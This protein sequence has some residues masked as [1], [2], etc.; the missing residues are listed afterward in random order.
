MM[1][2]ARSRDLGFPRRRL[3]GELLAD[4][5]FLHAAD[6]HLDSPLR[7]LSRYEGLPED[8]IRGA[9]RG[10]FDNLV[11]R[12]VD[13]AV[14]FVVIAG[15]LFDG[16]WKDMG[17]G[18]YF[19]RAMGRLHQAGIPVFLLA[20]NHDAASVITRSVPWPPNVRLFGTRKPE[21]HVLAELGVAVHGQSFST[22]AVTDNLVLAYPEATE[23]HFNIGM[24][25]TALAG[26]QGHAPYAPCSLDDLKA[27]QYDYWALGHVHEHEI[28]CEDPHV[29][30]P[31][32]TQGRT[33]RETGPK[34]AVIVTVE[35]GQVSLVDRI[36]LDVLRWAAVEVDCTGVSAAAAPE[37]MRAALLARWQDSAAG[38][39]LVAR[40]TLTGSTG[41][42]GALHDGAA[43]LRDDARAVAASISPDLFIEKVKVLVTPTAGPAGLA[44]GDDLAALIAQA[45][46]DPALSALLAEDL[47]PFLLAAQTS[48][49][50]SEDA[51][52]RRSAS[53]GDWAIVLGAATLA[54]R[55]RLTKEA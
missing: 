20:G 44:I 8:D 48:L 52:L 47:Q 6:I 33:I 21:T 23:H 49:G 55:S 41:D 22:P 31:G 7:G 3:R 36:E 15:D 18:L 45:A 26:R 30:F 29:V 38:M 10:A 43:G 51:D 35:D 12:A 24:L 25:H 11:Q 16:E 19:A 54:L 37:L 1:T 50:P 17:T 2:A 46:T 13:E 4:F 39:P 9:T 34:G 53:E 14:D 5:R 42:A 40:L 32:N 28:V 27:K